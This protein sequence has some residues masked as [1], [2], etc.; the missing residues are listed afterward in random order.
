M[1]GERLEHEGSGTPVNSLDRGLDAL[2]HPGQGVDVLVNAGTPRGVRSTSETP[3][4][5]RKVLGLTVGMAVLAGRGG[6][7]TLPV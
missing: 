3:S 1:H 4:C 2:E 7:R 5:R 6:L